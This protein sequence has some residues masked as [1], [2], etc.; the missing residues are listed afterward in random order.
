MTT[1]PESACR[2]LHPTP[3]MCHCGHAERDHLGLFGGSPN[4]MVAKDYPRAALAV[5]S[6]AC[7][8]VAVLWKLLEQIAR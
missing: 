6:L 7:V 5:V 3:R 4:R 1:L 8:V 2:E